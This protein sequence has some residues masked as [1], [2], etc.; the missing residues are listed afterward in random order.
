M[1]FLQIRVAAQASGQKHRSMVHQLCG[2]ARGLQ[3]FGHDL[4][5]VENA[6]TER[7]MRRCFVL[8]FVVLVA[9]VVGIDQMNVIDAAGRACG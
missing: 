3:Q 6:E 1:Y 5:E 8:A 2:N 7:R 4:I 9:G